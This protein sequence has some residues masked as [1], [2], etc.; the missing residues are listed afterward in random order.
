VTACAAVSFAA[1][2]AA[3]K[4]ACD[5]AIVG[6]EQCHHNLAAC[7]KVRDLQRIV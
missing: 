3:Q 2:L 7:H 1:S 6:N 5:D 4:Q